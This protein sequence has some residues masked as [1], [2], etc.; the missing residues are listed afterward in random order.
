LGCQRRS[1]DIEICTKKFPV[2][3]LTK[4]EDS[5]LLGHRFP[6]GFGEILPLWNWSAIL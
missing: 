3:P 4:T 5:F 6:L 2:A 1:V